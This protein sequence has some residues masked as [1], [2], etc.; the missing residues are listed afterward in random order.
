MK[1]VM[2]FVPT[3][4]YLSELYSRYATTLL[5][6]SP[7]NLITLILHFRN[8]TNLHPALNATAN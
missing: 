6:Q 5:P 8:S 3:S 1:I 2:A 7:K 4:I